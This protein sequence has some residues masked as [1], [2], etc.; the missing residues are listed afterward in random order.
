MLG[1]SKLLNLKMPKP[2]KCQVSNF[3]K[4]MP[5]VKLK[6][7]KPENTKSNVY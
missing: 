6:I 2:L 1:Q 3:G 5:K 7:P 4:K